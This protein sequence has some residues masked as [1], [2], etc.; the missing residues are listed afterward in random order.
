MSKVRCYLFQCRNLPAADD[1]GASD[2]IITIFNTI[3]SEGGEDLIKRQ[4]KETQ[5][6]ENNC[7]PMFYEV[8]ELTID[9]FDGEEFPPFIFDVYDVDKAFIT[10]D[11]RDYLGRAVI[12]LKDSSYKTV[13]KMTDSEDLKP[14]VPKWHPIRY[15]AGMPAS[16][17]IL[18]SFLFCVEF[19]HKLEKET[20]MGMYDD[21]AVVR[22]DDFKVE[23]N[24]LGLRNL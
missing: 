8:I 23:L 24:V 22:F 12:Q 20:M 9:Y 21:S 4:V 3:N 16:G 1:D 7:D 18:V 17:E 2:P 19:D 10:K 6:I 11:T 15:A 5:K 13:D 14:D